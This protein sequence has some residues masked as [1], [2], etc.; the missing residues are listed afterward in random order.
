MDHYD[1]GGTHRGLF[2]TRGKSRQF[3]FGALGC[4]I[5]RDSK[6]ASEAHPDPYNIANK[7]PDLG[8]VHVCHQCGAHSSRLVFYQGFRGGW[9]LVGPNL[10]D[11]SVD[12]QLSSEHYCGAQGGLTSIFDGMLPVH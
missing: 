9:F 3:F 2:Y 11:S 10:W 5:S 7:H 12:R 4:I 8:I 6:P 1:R